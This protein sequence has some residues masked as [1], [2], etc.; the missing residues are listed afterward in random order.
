MHRPSSRIARRRTFTR[1]TPSAGLSETYRPMSPMAFDPPGNRGS[2]ENVGKDVFMSKSPGCGASKC[3][4]KAWA[5]FC[6]G[7]A[8]SAASSMST[9]YKR[10]WK[11]RQEGQRETS[12]SGFYHL[13]YLNGR[14]NRPPRYTAQVTIPKLFPPQLNIR[15]IHGIRK[16]LNGCHLF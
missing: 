7:A 8:F 13:K 1:R 9:H 3:L 4:V 12:C 16:G 14:P 2:I 15:T 11:N 6:Y 10:G 5:S